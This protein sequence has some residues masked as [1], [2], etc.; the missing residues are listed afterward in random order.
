MVSI[1]AIGEDD[2]IVFASGRAEFDLDGMTLM[3]PLRP[4]A[5][6]GERLVT[7]ISARK[8]RHGRRR[9]LTAG[10]RWLARAPTTVSDA[11]RASGRLCLAGAEPW[12]CGER[13]F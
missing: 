8:G 6:C 4:G 9:N 3:T 12:M 5:D 2:T 13:D 10:G 11:S 1:R 7:I